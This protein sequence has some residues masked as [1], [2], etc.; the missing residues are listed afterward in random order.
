MSSFRLSY[1]Y[2]S[3]SFVLTPYVCLSICLSVSLSLLFSL[4]IYLSISTVCLF[5]LSLHLSLSLSLSLTTMIFFC[6]PCLHQNQ[7][8]NPCSFLT[9][10]CYFFFFFTALIGRHIFLAKPYMEHICY[11]VINYTMLDVF[12]TSAFY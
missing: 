5:S 7:Y 10:C 1:S 12:R 8:I 2:F 11:M 9:E 4:S 6:K 3:S